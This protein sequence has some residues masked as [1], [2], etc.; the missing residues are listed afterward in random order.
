M[1][2]YI[3]NSSFSGMAMSLL[4]FAITIQHY[5][6]IRAFWYKAGLY[7]PNTQNTFSDTNF[8]K[9]SFANINKDPYFTDDLD[10]ASIVDA[11]TCAICMILSFSTLVGRI[12]FL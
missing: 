11:I 8:N 12:Q 9:I 10:H 4:I 1:N 2:S 5:F 6:L 3:T 7:S